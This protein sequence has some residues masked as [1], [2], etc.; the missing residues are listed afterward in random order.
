MAEQGTVKWFNDARLR[1]HQPSK[2]RRRFVHFSRFKLALQELQEGQ[3]VQFDV[4]KAPKAGK[5]RTLPQSR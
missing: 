3:T 4:T 1:L 2:W 5:R